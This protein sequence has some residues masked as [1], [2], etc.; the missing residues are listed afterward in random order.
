MRDGHAEAEFVEGVEAF[1][2]GG[3]EHCLDASVGTD[4]IFHGARLLPDFDD[5]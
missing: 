4:E 2:T 1:S 5:R 3:V